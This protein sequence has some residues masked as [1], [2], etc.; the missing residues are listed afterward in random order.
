MFSC[1]PLSSKIHMAFSMFS[2]FQ[3]YGKND[4]NIGKKCS[5]VSISFQPNL[6]NLQP[7]TALISTA[8]EPAY[9][10]P[11]TTFT[12]NHKPQ[13]NLYDLWEVQRIC[14]SDLVWYQQVGMY[15]VL[16]VIR[17]SS[18][19]DK[20]TNWLKTT[21]KTE[22]CKYQFYINEDVYVDISCMNNHV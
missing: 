19:S 21:R 18:L 17:C 6:A 7:V 15:S 10:G 5:G 11:K 1:R 13:S 3:K 4:E 12:V 22:I 16:E 20:I 2:E 8:E 9:G 14:G